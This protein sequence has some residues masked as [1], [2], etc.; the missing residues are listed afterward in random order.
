MNGETWGE[1]L[2]RVIPEGAGCEACPFTHKGRCAN[3][4]EPIGEEKNQWCRKMM[5]VER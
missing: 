4:D 3:W 1:Y 5:K 2:Q